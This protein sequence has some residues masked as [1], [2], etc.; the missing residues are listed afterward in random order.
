VDGAA[1]VLAHALAHPPRLGASR[2]ICVDGPAGSGKTTIAQEIG[3]LADAQVVRLDD[4]Y[5]GWDG[6]F[7]VE[8]VVLGLLRPLAEGRPGHYRRYDWIAGEHQETHRVD[9]APL[10]VLDGVAAGN[11]AWRDLVTTLVWVHAPRAERL[12]R[13]VARDGESERDRLLAWMRDED[14]LYAEERT[15][16]AADLVIDT[17]A[18]AS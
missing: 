14:R 2:L 9:P 12:E 11:R 3:R 4:L 17:G 7:E 13:A 1:D 15:G 18:P 10:L 5:P 6:L 8:T 16:E